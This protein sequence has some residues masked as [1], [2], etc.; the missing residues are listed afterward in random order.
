MVKMG[1]L[2]AG[3][4]VTLFA[5]IGTSQAQFKDIR[6]RDPACGNIACTADYNPV[7]GSDGKTYSN[8]CHLGIAQRC[9]DSSLR[10]YCKGRCGECGYE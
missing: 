7:C 4:L 1:L 3:L 5:I 6:T 2:S 8:G 9:E 10:E